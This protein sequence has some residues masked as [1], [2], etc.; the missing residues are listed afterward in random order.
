MVNTSARRSLT[1]RK[2]RAWALIGDYPIQLGTELSPRC[3]Q[4]GEELVIGQEQPPSLASFH[5]AYRRPIDPTQAAEFLLAQETPRSERKE[6]ASG[7][8]TS[9]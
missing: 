8:L 6:G 5:A 7:L 1:R 9:E 3:A 2:L 4:A